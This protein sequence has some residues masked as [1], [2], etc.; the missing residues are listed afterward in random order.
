MDRK[1]KYILALQPHEASQHPIGK[2]AWSPFCLS[3]FLLMGLAF[4]IQTPDYWNEQVRV[5]LLRYAYGWQT[6]P[7]ISSVEATEWYSDMFN[8]VPKTGCLEAQVQDWK[9]MCYV[10][11]TSGM[12]I[13]CANANPQGKATILRNMEKSKTTRQYAC[14]YE[15]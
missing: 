9:L 4:S 12:D 11:T 6:S 2:S 10:L 5:G 7:L 3:L 13:D 1:K 8:K 14:L 15:N